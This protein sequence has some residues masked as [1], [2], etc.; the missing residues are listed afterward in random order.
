MLDSKIFLPQLPKCCS[1]RPLPLHSALG[2]LYVLEPSAF[3]GRYEVYGMRDL[4][5]LVETQLISNTAL[6]GCGGACL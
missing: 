4:A 3:S 2:R 5:H 1:H 6:D